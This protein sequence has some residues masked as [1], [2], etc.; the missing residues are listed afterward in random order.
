MKARHSFMPGSS[1][2]VASFGSLRY[3]EVSM[4][5]AFSG[6]AGLITVPTEADTLVMICSGFQPRSKILLIIC[7]ANFGGAAVLH[8]DG[9]AVD[10]GVGHFVGHFLDDM[11]GIIGPQRV[12][13]PD[14][15]ILAEIVVL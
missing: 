14:Q 13:Q 10:G 12:L 15:V 8:A 4:P 5:T 6:P 3:C 9:L 2:Q 11:L 1:F 7:A